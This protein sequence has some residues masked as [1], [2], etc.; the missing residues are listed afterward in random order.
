MLSIKKFAAID[1]G[2]NAVRLLISTVTEPD[3]KPVTFKKTSLVRVPIRLGQ[4]VFTKSY[5]SDESTERMIDT[6]KAFSL[7][8]KSHRIDAYRACATSAMRDA[9]N[10]KAVAEKIAS[11]CKID[12]EIIDGSDEASIIAATDLHTLVDNN[13]TYLYVDVGGGSTEFTL[14]SEGK[15]I[16]S[17]SFKLGTVR[18]LNNTITE[19]VWSEAEQWIKDITKPYSRIEMVG[20]GG[21]INNIF[22]SSNKKLGKPLSYFYLS[23]YYQLLNSLT[24]EERIS[25]L[26]LNEDRADVIIPATKIY[27]SAM[28]WSKSKS[29][30]VP[31]IGLVDGIIKSL[32]QNMKLVKA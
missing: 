6:M 25:E 32:Y 23:S 2:S 19:E 10:G 18:I 28:K 9:K 31:K 7:L 17:K 5:I 30:H 4:D 13:K 15:T 21:N 3:N 12:I 26:S 1:I 14:F 16:E 8:M 11:E 29:V 20:S 27:L 22:K 24:F